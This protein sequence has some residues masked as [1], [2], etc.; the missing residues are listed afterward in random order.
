MLEEGLIIHLAQAFFCGSSNSMIYNII[1]QL[2]NPRITFTNHMVHYICYMYSIAACA[3]IEN[4]RREDE[5]LLISHTM[6]YIVN[7]GN[8]TKI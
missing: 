4:F 3:K 5:H 7:R 1:E 2:L 8:T 6:F